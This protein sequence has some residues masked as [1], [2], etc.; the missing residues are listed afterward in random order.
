MEKKE[1]LILEKSFTFSLSIIELFKHLKS[2]NGFIISKQLLRSGT[3]IGAN[4]NESTAAQSKADFIH[5]MSIASKEARETKYWLML[6]NKSQL[7]VINLDKYLKEIDEIINILTAIVKTSQQN[8]KNL[9]LGFVIQN[10]I[11]LKR[12]KI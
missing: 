12:D 9:K 10:P 11:P 1:N 8:N 7:V 4:I 3:S 6:L 5:K 2:N